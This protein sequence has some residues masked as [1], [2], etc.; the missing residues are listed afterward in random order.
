MIYTFDSFQIHYGAS[1]LSVYEFL[2][3]FI[4]KLSLLIISLSACTGEQPVWSDFNTYKT[5]LD[6]NHYTFP[7]GKG[8][9][10]FYKVKAKYPNLDVLNFYS[11]IIQEPWVKCSG[12]TQWESFADTSGNEPLFV[13]QS[14]QR[15]VNFE[16]NR[17]L[18]LAIKYRSPGSQKREK[19]DNNVQNIYLAEYL[20]PNI[21]KTLTAIGITCK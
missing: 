2:M 16:Q 4:I 13:H 21:R 6:V 5:A 15:W 3:R 19:P 18:F 9:Q 11:E 7:N 12:N 14:V 8:K 20:E 10:V 1:F 17:L